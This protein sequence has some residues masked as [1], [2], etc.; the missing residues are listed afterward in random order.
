MNT[1]SIQANLIDIPNRT[2]YGAEIFIQDGIIDSIV[3]TN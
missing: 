2:I 3:P 1:F